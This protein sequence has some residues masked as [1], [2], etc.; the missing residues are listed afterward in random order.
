MNRRTLTPLALAG[1]LASTLAACSGGMSGKE[2]SGGTIV[3]GTTARVA[4]TEDTPAPFDP[5]A[6]YDD[7]SW[8]IMRNTFQTLL[9]PPRTGTEPV[10]DA[11]EKCGFT[12][13]RNE[14]YSCTLREGLTFS[15]GNKLNAEDVEFS[16]ERLL[17]IDFK[18]GPASLF[19]NVDEVEAEAG[20]KVVFHLKKP[21]ATFPYKLATPA[22]SIVDSQTYPA[23]RL[24]K[25]FK[26]TGSGPYVLDDFDAK[27]RKVLLSG[28]PDYRGA[29][30][31]K[32]EKI[33]LR[34]FNSSKSL[35]KALDSGDVDLMNGGVSS[36]YIEQLEADRDDQIKL[37][38]QPGQAVRYLVFDTEDE[39]VGRR[40]V[41]QAFAQVIDRK[42]LVST[43][44]PR[45]AEPLFSVVPGGLVGHTNSF[46]NEYGEPDEKAA[47]R[48]LRKADVKTPVRLSLHYPQVGKGG[49]GAKEFALLEKQLN[50]SGLFDA[51]VEIEPPTSYSTASLRGEYQVY[52]FAW[53]PDFPDADNFIAPFFAKD[54]VLNSPYSSKEI[55]EELIPDTRREPERADASKSFARA[56]DIVADDVPVLPLWQGKQ[57]V[58]AHD[59]ITGVEWAL[60]SSSLLQLWE[61]DRGVSS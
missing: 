18:G 8:N 35:Q 10:T 11:A 61:L 31:A 30:R 2:G 29:S 7:S 13:K 1:L 28:N 12:D 45:T 49:S 25:G 57:Y 43:V 19:S 59:D 27:R 20:N 14:Q 48:T 39:T 53:L 26:G 4:V 42:Q 52:G 41:R 17:L 5:A 40:A 24:A 32:S 3:V 55:R 6:S 46:F 15:N 38:E 54:N 47:K 56:Q 60:N 50:D 51:S 36:R 9:R 16:L 23:D 21:D 34:F 44:Y 33:E 22:A 37:V 58:A